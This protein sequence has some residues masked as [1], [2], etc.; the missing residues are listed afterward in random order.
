MLICFE[1]TG[2][3]SFNLSLFLQKNAVP[4]VMLPALE[5]KRSLGMTRVKMTRLMLNA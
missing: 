4:F 2:L 3:Y 5:I 1:H